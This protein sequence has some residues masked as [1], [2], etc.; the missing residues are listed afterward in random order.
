LETIDHLLDISEIEPGVDNLR[1]VHFV[2]LIR[3]LEVDQVWGDCNNDSLSIWRNPH[4]ET[5]SLGERADSLK[6]SVSITIAEALDFATSF[7]ARTDPTIGVATHFT[8]KQSAT[9]VEAHSNRINNRGFRCDQFHLE[10]F[11][12]VERS[13]LVFRRTR[14]GR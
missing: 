4:W 3:V 5:Q 7:V 6:S 9:R 11:D 2:I 10:A 12:D 14:S 13:S 8:H 1:L